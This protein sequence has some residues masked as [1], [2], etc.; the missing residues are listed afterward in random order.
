M[1]TGAPSVAPTRNPSS[2]S[3][4]FAPTYQPSVNVKSIQDEG[5]ALFDMAAAMPGLKSISG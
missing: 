2:T 3:P 5:N 4:S 1:S